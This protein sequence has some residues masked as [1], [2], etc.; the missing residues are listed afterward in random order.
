MPAIAVIGA[1]IG[2]VFAA[3]VSAKVVAGVKATMLAA[4]TPT[5][6]A[7]SG[8]GGQ[9]STATTEIRLNFE[10]FGE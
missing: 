10:M 2:I 1:E 3:L 7:V 4:D 5:S 9:S 8:G 6:T